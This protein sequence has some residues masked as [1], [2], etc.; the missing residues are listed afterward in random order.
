MRHLYETIEQRKVTIIESPTGTVNLP[1]R[2]IPLLN[3]EFQGKTLSL[4]CA[5]L[6]WLSD[7]RE[8][9]RRGMLKDMIGGENSG[10]ELH[11][12]YFVVWR[13]DSCL[14]ATAKSWVFEQTLARIRRD[15]EMDEREYQARLTNAR[16]REE[17]LRRA[18][19]ARVVKRQVRKSSPPSTST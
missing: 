12:K 16:K 4:L 14:C 18:A 8:R 2:Y 11:T 13:L 1:P 5:S 7:D 3:R 9:A 17:A 10:G 15:M 6:T 19:G